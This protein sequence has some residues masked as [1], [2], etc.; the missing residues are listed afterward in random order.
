MKKL[1]FQ[2]KIDKWKILVKNLLP[3]ILQ[4]VSGISGMACWMEKYMWKCVFCL[5]FFLAGCTASGPQ[6]ALDEMAS[7]MENNNPAAFM[8]H[9]NMKEFAAN[10]TADLANTDDAL[11]ALNSLGNLFG[12]GNLDEFIG[13][14]INFQSQLEQRFERGVAS[15]ELMI[16]CRKSETPDCPWVPQSLRDAKIIEIDQN[17]AIAK[18]TTP[19]KLTSWLAMRKFGEQWKVVGNAVLEST[20]RKYA[21]GKIGLPAPDQENQAAKDI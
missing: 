16:Q 17:A 14:I 13:S 4:H 11:G 7:A 6:K 8:Y 1:F 9:L 3:K 18:I 10:Y 2:A 21:V 12:I 20:A 5:L 19:A 15:G